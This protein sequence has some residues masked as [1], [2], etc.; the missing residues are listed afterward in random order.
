MEAYIVCSV[1]NDSDEEDI[2]RIRVYADHKKNEM[3][4]SSIKEIY[5]ELERRKKDDTSV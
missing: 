1:G 2:N 3:N 5:E 4:E